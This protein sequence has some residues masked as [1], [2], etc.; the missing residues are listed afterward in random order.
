MLD[1]D[2][3]D[4]ITKVEVFVGKEVREARADVGG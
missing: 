3:F 1:R 4:S 2:I